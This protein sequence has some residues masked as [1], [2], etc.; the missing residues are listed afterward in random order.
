MVW[1][2]ALCCPR[3]SRRRTIYD[4]GPCLRNNHGNYGTDLYADGRTRRVRSDRA[5]D[6]L[7]GYRIRGRPLHLQIIIVATALCRR[8]PRDFA[9][10]ERGDY[11][12]LRS[13]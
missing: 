5:R 13:P 1:T 7:L 6:Y 3:P 2:R 9:S 12:E 10:T 4:D 8:V 11:I